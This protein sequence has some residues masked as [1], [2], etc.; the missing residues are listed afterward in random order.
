MEYAVL[1][2]TTPD[3]PRRNPT[4]RY[5]YRGDSKE[6]ALDVARRYQRPIDRI[7]ARVFEVATEA[8]GLGWIGEREIKDA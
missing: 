3:D 6:F 1:V 4:H 7:S 2:Q 8:D 5:V